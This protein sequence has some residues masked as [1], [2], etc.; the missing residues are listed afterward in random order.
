MTQTIQI[1]DGVWPVML[2]PFLENKEID[3]DG[4]DTLIDWY[5][6]GGVAGLFAVCLSSE[7]YSLTP[8]ECVQLS[9]RVVSSAAGRV[10]VVSAG[11]FG[12]A[13][14]EQATMAERL[15]AT[16]VQAV[17]LTTN[18]L[19]AEGADEDTWRKE[20]EAFLKTTRDIPLG[21]YECPK[22]YPFLLSPAMMK[23][24]AHTGRFHFFKDTCCDPVQLE[25]KIQAVQGTPLRLFNANAQT[26]LGSLRAGASGY[27]SIDAN[28]Y[29]DL[30]T[31]LCADFEKD[32]EKAESL[33]A[34]LS[35]ANMTT[36]NKYPLSAKKFLALRGLPIQPV[37]RIETQDFVPEE[38]AVLKHLL[39]L[40]LNRI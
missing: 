7:M 3:W 31:R 28:F 8:D 14:G 12:N 32:P 20:A 26:L 38:E 22:P 35:V 39:K 17:V 21:I 9:E 11:A 13:T 24:L 5:I 37:C 6:D 18:Q 29:P 23:W 16:G 15:Y 10:P 19:V 27:S 34:F 36:R 4:L 33:Q 30:Y 2:T 1:P 25:A 40:A